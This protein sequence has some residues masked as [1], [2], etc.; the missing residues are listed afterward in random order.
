LGQQFDRR[1][2]EFA[3]ASLDVGFSSHRSLGRLVGRGRHDSRTLMP[4]KVVSRAKINAFRVPI[5]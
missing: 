2:A 1:V 5:C 3:S 4:R